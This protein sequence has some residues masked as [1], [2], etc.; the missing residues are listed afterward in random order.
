MTIIFYPVLQK[1]ISRF[2]NKNT[3]F[4]QLLSMEDIDGNNPLQFTA[5]RGNIEII[6]EL[7]NQGEDY[8]KIFRFKCF[9][10]G[11]KR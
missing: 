6:K 9:I 1:F 8:K 10:Y 3:I 2:G 11:N 5:F 7:I 4:P